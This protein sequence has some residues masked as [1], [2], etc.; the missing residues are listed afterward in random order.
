MNYPELRAEI[1]AACVEMNRRGMNQGVS[2]NISARIPEGFLITPLGDGVSRD[3][4]RG[5]RG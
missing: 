5:H 2:G 3:A 1:I 4:A